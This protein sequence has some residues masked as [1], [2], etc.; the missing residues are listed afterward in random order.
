MNT[1]K[2][3]IIK[4]K[5]TLEI[6]K[7]KLFLIF[8]YFFLVLRD[9]FFLARYI[10]LLPKYISDIDNKIYIIIFKIFNTILYAALINNLFNISSILSKNDSLFYLFIYFIFLV[11]IYYLILRFYNLKRVLFI[12]F[13]KY[14]HI[15]IAKEANIF[16]VRAMAARK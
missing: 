13:Q 6:N 3:Q 4:L 10:K 16:S 2:N 14:P 7:I 5:L 1:V 15:I 11:I 12:L 9:V 8:K